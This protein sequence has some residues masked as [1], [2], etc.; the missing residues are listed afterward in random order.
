MAGSAF[1]VTCSSA[2]FRKDSSSARKLK[3]LLASESIN[4]PTA[5]LESEDPSLTIFLRPATSAL[6]KFLSMAL[7]A[8][9]RTDSTGSCSPCTRLIA[10]LGEGIRS[11]AS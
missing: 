9:I 2:S 11:I 1:F 3:I 5:F 10:V 6:D 4:E 7:A 8:L